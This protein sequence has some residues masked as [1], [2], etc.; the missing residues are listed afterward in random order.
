MIIGGVNLLLI[1][2]AFDPSD[3]FNN[4]ENGGW[5]DPSDL[6]TL[7]QD[8]AGTTA[9]TTSGQSVA[10]I[11][12]KS[13]S[14]H[15][16]TQATAASRPTYQ[17]SGGLH[18]LD[19]D[20]TDD[21]LQETSF[22]ASITDSGGALAVSSASNN[23][24]KIGGLLEEL[25]QGSSGD[26]GRNIIYFDTRATPRRIANYAPDSTGGTVDRLI[27]LDAEIDSTAKVFIFNSDGTSG[28]AYL[29][30]VQQGSTVSTTAAFPSTTKITIGRQAAGPSYHDGKLYGALIL[31]RALTTQERSD[32]NTWLSDKAGI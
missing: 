23:A 18:W 26:T 28:S 17:T 14:G 27:D 4:G 19:F 32:L 30:N 3:L 1:R 9:V 15:H 25:V 11:D 16:L 2:S 20:G 6:S 13:G 31:D 29:D 8:T 7:W 12:D 21:Y 10:R 24:E 22:T 5:Y